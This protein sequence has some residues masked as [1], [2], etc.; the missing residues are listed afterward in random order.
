MMHGI[1]IFPYLSNNC[2][3][4]KLLWAG[5]LF[6]ALKMDIDQDLRDYQKEYLDFIDDEAGF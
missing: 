6:G 5:I 1:R 2:Y 4:L 3:K